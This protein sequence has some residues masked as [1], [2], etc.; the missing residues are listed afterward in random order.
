MESRSPAGKRGKILVVDDE[1]SIV[2]TLAAILQRQGY[3]TATATSGDAAVQTAASFRPDFLLSDI[4]M[5]PGINGVE[6]AIK[7]LE[8]LP[9]CRVLFMSGHAAAQD[10]LADARRRGFSFEV[11]VKPV[12]PEALLAK[13]AEIN[14]TR[15]VLTILNVD[16]NEIERYAVSRLL[17]H[18]GFKVIEAGTGTQ[19]LQQAQDHPDL[20]L[21]DI[22]LPDISGFEVCRQLKSAPETAN[23]PIV[24]L[25]NTSRDSASRELALRYGADG[26]VTHPAEPDTLFSLL[27]RLAAASASR[28]KA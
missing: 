6:A 12:A 26:F 13:V 3:E 27:R 5:A 18:A 8:F 25:T 9:E 10:V 21:L 17:T 23:I 1:E 15:P 7:I 16:D 2:S 20:I 24:H 19:A 28:S 11:C 14:S 22:N 4:R